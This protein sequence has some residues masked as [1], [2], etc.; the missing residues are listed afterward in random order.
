MH[1]LPFP[2]GSEDAEIGGN[3]RR[4]QQD[5]ELDEQGKI[6]ALQNSSWRMRAYIAKGLINPGACDGQERRRRSPVVDIDPQPTLSDVFQRAQALVR[7]SCAYTASR[8]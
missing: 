1:L 3:K 5:D 2:D 8:S 7:S 6:V 4:R